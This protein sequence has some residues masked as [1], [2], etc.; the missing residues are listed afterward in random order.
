M[1]PFHNT[2]TKDFPLIYGMNFTKLMSISKISTTLCAKYPNWREFFSFKSLSLRRQS[3]FRSH[4]LPSGVNF[5][6]KV[7]YVRNSV[8]NYGCIIK[9]LVDINDDSNAIFHQFCLRLHIHWMK[10]SAEFIMGKSLCKFY[11]AGSI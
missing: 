3:F 11:L 7:K 8:S 9:A 6:P 5:D 4:I 10:S 1:Y 2:C